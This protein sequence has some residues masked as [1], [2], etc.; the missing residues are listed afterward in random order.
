MANNASRDLNLSQPIR[1][2]KVFYLLR[3]LLA[4][5]W[6]LKTATQPPVVMTDMLELVDQ[7][8]QAE[9]SALID[10]KRMQDESYIHELS[11]LMIRTI[12]TLWDSIDNP[13]FAPS[14]PSNIAPL[15]DFYRQVVRAL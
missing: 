4:A 11:P 13:S 8:V 9:I 6:I 7:E 15:N 2:K 1:L 12:A 10:V 5:K 3:A 14:T